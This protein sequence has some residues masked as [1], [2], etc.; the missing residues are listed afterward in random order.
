MTN[1][2]QSL[3]DMLEYLKHVREFTPEGWEVF[4]HDKKTQ[5]AVIRAYEVIGEIVKRLPQIMR[6]ANPQIDW[7]KLMGFRDFLAHNYNEIILEFVWAAV[8]D[9]PNL[10]A[11]IES[12]LRDL[13][14]TDS[15]VD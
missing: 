7:R 3:L 13:D 5:L 2:R 12:L 8:E 4:A 14:A 10:Y 15:E 9:A 6:D 1:V 11:A